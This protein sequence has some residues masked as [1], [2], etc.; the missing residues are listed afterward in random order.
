MFLSEDNW[1]S[2]NGRLTRIL[3]EETSVDENVQ[4]QHLKQCCACS[5]AKY[6]VSSNVLTYLN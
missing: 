4:P 2:E 5:E 3:C 6:E 1:Y